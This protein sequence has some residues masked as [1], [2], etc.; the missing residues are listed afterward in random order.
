LNPEDE[1]YGIAK[2][3]V[4]AFIEELLKRDEP[5]EWPRIKRLNAPRPRLPAHCW[6]ALRQALAFDHQQRPDSQSLLNAFS[7]SPPTLLMRLLGRTP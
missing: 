2:R 4:S 6:P 5:K 7:A 3:G 1:A